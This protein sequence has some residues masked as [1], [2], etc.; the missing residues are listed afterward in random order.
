MSF[1]IFFFLYIIWLGVPIYY[2]VGSMAYA[3]PP[4]PSVDV[5]VIGAG[6]SGMGVADQLER[7]KVSNF[8]ILEATNRTGGRTEAIEFGNSSVGRFMFEVGSNW[9]CGTPRSGGPTHKLQPVYEEALRVKKTQ[10]FDITLIP[11]GTQNQ[12]NYRS[13]Y[14][15]NGR[16]VDGDG[17]IR[18]KANA[19]MDCMN[20]TASH[21][22]PDLTLRQAAIDCDWN[23]KTDAEL[24]VDWG[25]L[26]DENGIFAKEQ[27]VVWT[28]PDET[29]E[30]WGNDDYFV[31]DQ[32]PR[33]YAHL[34]DTMMTDTIPKG[35]PR[36][37]FNT[38]VTE[39][40]YSS[41]PVKVTS[42]DGRVFHAKAVISALPLGVLQHNHAS[43]FVPPLPEKQVAALTHDSAI[44]SN[45]TKIF[46]QFKE[47]FW[48]NMVPRW[49]SADNEYGAFPEWHNMNHRDHVPG[50][51]TLFIWLGQ[52]QSTK[53]ESSTDEEVKSAL[54]KYIRQHYPGKNIPEPVAFYMTRHS[55]NPFRYGAY[56]AFKL[57]W[58]DHAHDDMI[59]PL[60][61]HGD[62]RVYF[63]GEHTCD[64][65]NGFTH[66]A[67]IRGREVAMDYLGIKYKSLCDW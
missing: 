16:S 43:L 42:K 18:R 4:P 61:V 10:K 26:V 5:I 58:T 46:I 28:Y 54:M 8:L 38:I 13:V 36:L 55:L 15:R 3:S 56:S 21:A 27:A 37:M 57:G 67:L 45:L 34:L 7:S 23:P 33:G 52:P 29:Y 32:N 20:K 11:G 41:S 65:L 53:W 44:M 60:E 39:I 50:S 1:S 35:D 51:N 14:D 25:F 49:L 9:I 12:S 22:K 6:W 2:R 66:G 30:W 19:V 31:V 59:K 40:D 64:D 63:A 47:P 62:T 48:N 17:N 24:A